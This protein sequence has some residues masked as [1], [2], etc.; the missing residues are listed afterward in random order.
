MNRINRPKAF[1]FD[2]DGVLVNSERVWHAEAALLAENVYG[3]EILAKLGD[4]QGLSIDAE[5]QLAVSHGFTMPRDEYDAIVDQVASIVYAKSELTERIDETL[6]RLAAFGYGVGIVT[7]SRRAW[8]ETVLGRI[9][10]R[11]SFAYQLSM[12]ER[13][14]LQSKPHPDGYLEAMRHFGVT[15]ERTL[16]LEDS[17]SGI[18]SAKAAG[19]TVIGFRAN[20]VDGYVQD[21]ADFY[22]DTLDDVVRIAEAFATDD[23]AG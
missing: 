13:R 3:P 11:A 23:S 20:L 9:P 8:L 6:E 15:P 12:D 7:S 10:S 5:Y 1:L 19:A 22:A 16:V 2:M 17:N 21:S 18:R 14:D 4:T